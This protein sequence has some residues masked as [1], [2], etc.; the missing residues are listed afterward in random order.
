MN[1]E[2]SQYK[3][4][5][6]LNPDN[7]ITEFPVENNEA[8]NATQFDTGLYYSSKFETVGV[9]IRGLWF[10]CCYGQHIISG[11]IIGRHA[12]TAAL[13]K[14]FL[15]GK[16]RFVV[17]GLEDGTVKNTVIKEYGEY[18]VPDLSDNT[19]VESYGGI[20]IYSGEYKDQLYFYFIKRGRLRSF[21]EIDL[22]RK[23]IDNGDNNDTFCY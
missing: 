22:T 18:F 10:A 23:A 8:K 7:F 3:P 2:F 1:N 13:L 20:E 6:Y 12:C 14:G 21:K 16:A 5:D 17:C 15:H 4:E 11:E 19:L 9:T